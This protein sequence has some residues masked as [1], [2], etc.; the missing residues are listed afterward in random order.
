MKKKKLNLIER[1]KTSKGEANW[2]SPKDL[3]ALALSEICDEFNIPKAKRPAFC[4]DIVSIRN[5]LAGLISDMKQRGANSKHRD[6]WA[7]HL[8]N[9]NLIIRQLET[10]VEYERQRR[11]RAYLEPPVVPVLSEVAAQFLPA[12]FDP[13][14][15]LP[16]EGSTPP[17][18][19]EMSRPA[20]MNWLRQLGAV[21][22]AA[23]W[24]PVYITI[25]DSV[26]LTV[27]KLR[28]LTESSRRPQNI[29]GP[30]LVRAFR[31]LG[32]EYLLAGSLDD[33]VHGPVCMLLQEFCQEIGLP[34]SWIMPHFKKPKQ[35]RKASQ[36]NNRP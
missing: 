28:R 2:P 10:L 13:R 36:K 7:E 18:M 12:L 14:L 27:K 22:H 6:D 24:L 8:K 26:E 31:N 35:G 21:H 33:G 20:H 34:T 25:R 11:G 29:L 16:I 32:G 5:D 15:L 4:R 23:A 3:P 17:H 1:E 19:A 9:L 30:A